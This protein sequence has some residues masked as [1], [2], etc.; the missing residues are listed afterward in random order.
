M[1]DTPVVIGYNTKHPELFE[2]LEFSIKRHNPS[3]KVLWLDLPPVIRA[4][5][6]VGTTPHSFTRFLV[7]HMLGYKGRALFLDDDMVCL[8]DIGPLL[9]TNLRGCPLAVVKHDYA[10]SGTAKMGGQAQGWYRRK[11]WS[12]CM[13]M[14]C[15]K[16]RDWTPESVANMPASWLHGL[17][18]WDDDEILGLA[19]KWNN[20]AHPTPD[21]VL[22]HYTCGISDWYGNGPTVDDAHAD[23][24]RTV[25]GMM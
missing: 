20:V 13:L 16:L 19:E 7:P 21:T 6:K 15:E 2:T 18:P 8:G 14:D 12:S 4:D 9:A 23:I 25:R 10:T 22:F 17:E 3:V 24:W 5:G 1:S 11:L